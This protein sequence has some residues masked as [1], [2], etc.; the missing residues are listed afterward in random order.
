VVCAIAG[1][2]LATGLF[3][4][5]G[6]LSL[7]DKVMTLVACLGLAGL[8]YAA[9][10]GGQTLLHRVASRARA[11]A[12]M[13]TGV[14]VSGG[15]AV[16][17]GVP[18]VVDLFGSPTSLAVLVIL[19]LGLGGVLIIHEPTC[20]KRTRRARLGAVVALVTLIGVLAL[21]PAQAFRQ[22][23]ASPSGSLEDIAGSP[24]TGSHVA[25]TYDR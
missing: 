10:Y 2:V 22:R 8:G 7:P 18:F 5:S 3:V 9:A 15:I 23:S 11:G 4:V 6:R 24:V 17:I 1:F 13:L 14:L 12:A 21:H 25:H 19:M 16:W 20:S